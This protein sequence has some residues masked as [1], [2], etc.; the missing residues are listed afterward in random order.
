M[1]DMEYESENN[2]TLKQYKPSATSDK[3]VEDCQKQGD[4]K[5]SSGRG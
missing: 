4:Y 5:Q 2:G 1:Y 3:G